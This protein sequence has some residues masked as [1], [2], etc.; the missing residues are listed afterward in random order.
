MRTSHYTQQIM[1]HIRKKKVSIKEYNFLSKAD[2]NDDDDFKT[3]TV[4]SVVFSFYSFHVIPSAS[5]LDV[6]I[7]IF[8][9]KKRW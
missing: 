2:K 9:G 6:H 4:F 1:E 7:F 3:D 5:A 8:M